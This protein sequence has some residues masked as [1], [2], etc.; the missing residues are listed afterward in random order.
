MAE[1]RDKIDA[2][3]NK[4]PAKK[5]GDKPKDDKPKD[6]KDKDGEGHERQLPTT[7]PSDKVVTTAAPVVTPTKAVTDATKPATTGNIL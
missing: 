2:G 4:A 6:A 5:D 3:K 7:K 1:K